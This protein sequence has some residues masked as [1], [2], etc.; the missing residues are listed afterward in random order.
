MGF[1]EIPIEYYFPRNQIVVR[2]MSPKANIKLKKAT[3]VYRVLDLQHASAKN[4]SSPVCFSFHRERG[5][6]GSPHEYTVEKGVREKKFVF[7]FTQDG[8]KVKLPKS[9]YYLDDVINWLWEKYNAVGLIPSTSHENWESYFE[10][11]RDRD[12]QEQEMIERIA[13]YIH[14]LQECCLNTSNDVKAIA[15]RY[16]EEMGE[17]LSPH[18]IDRDV[19]KD[20]IIIMEPSKEVDDPLNRGKLT[21]YYVDPDRKQESKSMDKEIKGMF[22]DRMNDYFV[23]RFREKFP[24]PKTYSQVVLDEY[25]LLLN[26]K[27]V[28]E[29]LPSP[30][31]LFP[32]TIAQDGGNKIQE[33]GLM[34]F[35]NQITRYLDPEPGSDQA[36][37]KTADKEHGHVWLVEAPGA[38]GKSTLAFELF[39]YLSSEYQRT[40]WGT[41]PVLIHASIVRGKEFVHVLG[42]VFK[43]NLDVI[44]TIRHSCRAGKRRMICIVDG[45]DECENDSTRKKLIDHCKSLQA[46]NV[47]LIMT[48]RPDGLIT[49]QVT[50]T[51]QSVNRITLGCSDIFL[52]DKRIP[53]HLRALPYLLDVLFP[54]HDFPQSIHTPLLQ[55]EIDT[56]LIP[57]NEGVFPYA[58]LYPVSLSKL[59]MIFYEVS[60]AHSKMKGSLPKDKPV[61]EIIEAGMVV[62][63]DLLEGGRLTTTSK[64]KDL[65]V[66][67]GLLTKTYKDV[68]FIHDIILQ[69]MAARAIAFHEPRFPDDKV[70]N[71]IKRRPSIGMHAVRMGIESNKITDERFDLF[72]H[73]Y[74]DNGCDF[75]KLKAHV[76]KA[77]GIGPTPLMELAFQKYCEIWDARYNDDQEFFQQES[78]HVDVDWLSILHSIGVSCDAY[79]NEMLERKEWDY[80]DCFPASAGNVARYLTIHPTTR[81]G[82]WSIRPWFHSILALRDPWTVLIEACPRVLVTVPELMLVDVLHPDK[83]K[84]FFQRYFATI[85]ATN[86]NEII[87]TYLSNA[88]HYPPAF[89]DLSRLTREERQAFTPVACDLFEQRKQYTSNEEIAKVLFHIAS[90]TTNEHDLYQVIE[91]LAYM[92]ERSNTFLLDD[93]GTFTK[94]LKRVSSTNDIMVIY[95]Y[96]LL[97]HLNTQSMEFAI[98]VV[99]DISLVYL[100]LVRLTEKQDP[101]EDLLK[102]VSNKM[103]MML[104]GGPDHEEIYR[105]FLSHGQ[106]EPDADFLRPLEKKLHCSSLFRPRPFPVWPTI[107]EIEWLI[108]EPDRNKRGYIHLRF[109]MP[110]KDHLTRLMCKQGGF[111]LMHEFSDFLEVGKEG[112]HQLSW[113]LRAVD[114]SKD[115]FKPFLEEIMVHDE[116]WMQLKGVLAGEISSSAFEKGYWSSLVSLLRGPD[117]TSY[118]IPVLLDMFKEWSIPDHLRE[119]FT[120]SEEMIEAFLK[121]PMMP[122]RHESW[123]QLYHELLSTHPDLGLKVLEWVLANK[124]GHPDF[125]HK[126]GMFLANYDVFRPVLKEWLRFHKQDVKEYMRETPE[127][128]KNDRFVEDYLV[129]RGD[130]WELNK[131]NPLAVKTFLEKNKSNPRYWSYQASYQEM[132]PIAWLAELSTE[133]ERCKASLERA[134][135]DVSDAFDE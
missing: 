105:V 93:R 96:N 86:N 1:L 38:M 78:C 62:A 133:Q 90:D 28:D 19:G 113:F 115:A 30:D 114:E 61:D 12:K 24:S 74:D 85:L 65:L 36:G 77:R 49:R 75:S 122:G 60:L 134:G 37:E 17:K 56:L 31:R 108:E 8:E 51:L 2:L 41:V 48:T 107:D 64:E 53:Q 6:D 66:N 88:F 22:P 52:K 135:V 40:G 101:E 131:V 99:D 44:T 72:E 42:D 5:L 97:P 18:F 13:A 16:F 4:A 117:M 110:V 54:Y 126:I 47:F 46:D 79:E 34:F 63:M 70:F 39:K 68:Q 119:E 92:K 21:W 132:E 95:F 83:S 71:V 15:G 102:R 7:T 45:L 109:T 118:R 128:I 33:E 29:N 130:I 43:D 125:A 124:G 123:R 14:L 58:R 89:P 100:M 106:V 104:K 67:A 57:I 69:D 120:A 91:T 76:W 32:F 10:D 94:I 50:E 127:A 98:D 9:I 121:M 35:K 82:G 25:A 27:R 55:A 20:P 59:I 3:F 111:S 87:R 23:E 112:L 11:L 116:P 84:V 80:F 103:K 26:I 73:L 129:D 81:D